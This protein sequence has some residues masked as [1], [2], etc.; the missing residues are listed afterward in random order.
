MGSSGTRFDGMFDGATTFNSN[1]EQ[2]A[3]DNSMNFRGMFNK[4]SSF[5]SN[6][7]QWNVSSAVI[8]DDMF[9]G[10]TSFDQNLAWTVQPTASTTN[11]FLGS[12][13]SILSV[14]PTT[15]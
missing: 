7:N 3:V 12:S 13:G 10:A 2:W 8:L 9:S 6:L 14:P 5:N 11:M 15:T 4:A 1:L